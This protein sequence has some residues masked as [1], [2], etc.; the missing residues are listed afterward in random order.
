MVAIVLII[1][2]SAKLNLYTSLASTWLQLLYITLIVQYFTCILQE[3]VTMFWKGLYK[4]TFWKCELW[5]AKSHVSITVWKTWKGSGHYMPSHTCMPILNSTEN[6]CFDK[7]GYFHV[8]VFYGLFYKRNR[9]HESLGELE[10]GR[11]HSPCRLVF[12][13]Q[14]PNFHLCFY[15][16]METQKMFIYFLIRTLFFKKAFIQSVKRLIRTGQWTFYDNWSIYIS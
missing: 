9:R 12:P 1:V 4:I 15:N 11:K 6:L 8:L 10:I 7:E 16:C 5:L 2:I 14:L 13:L 3:T